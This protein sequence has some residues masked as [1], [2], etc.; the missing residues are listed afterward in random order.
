M[1]DLQDMLAR[2]QQRI[3]AGEDYELLDEVPL[4]SPRTGHI[5]ARMCVAAEMYYQNGHTLA[6]RLKAA[7]V[8]RDYFGLFPDRLRYFMASGD[9]GTVTIKN[10]QCPDLDA[11]AR[12]RTPTEPPDQ[13]FG[14]VIGEEIKGDVVPYRI[15]SLN[16]GRYDIEDYSFI[17]AYFPFR[18][19]KRDGFRPLLDAVLRWA[20]VI[21]P[22]F[23][24]AGPGFVTESITAY[25]PLLFPLLQLVPGL[26]YT[27][28]VVTGL[29]MGAERSKIKGM[30]WL[31]VLHDRFVVMLG[32]LAQ[33]HA[34]L[35]PTCT[36]HA[37]PGGIVIQAGPRPDLGD[38]N[39]GL[40]AEPYRRVAALLDLL[41]FDDYSAGRAGLF[42]VPK[43]L[44]PA[45]MAKQ[46]VHRFARLKGP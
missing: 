23:G 33:V 14:P 35:E 29:A 38:A 43:P 36:I 42:P 2:F 21:Q 11:A 1:T 7:A 27:N 25:G 20:E 12:E 24:L 40:I 34:V 15:I 26:E 39:L 45:E 31:T 5:R 41:I 19:A 8:L 18:W 32:G 4:T 10:G 37:Y 28:P 17:E 13:G 9:K 46:W 44:V 22:D 30:N 3:D 6:V 16:M